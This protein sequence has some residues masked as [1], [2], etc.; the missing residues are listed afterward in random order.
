MMSMQL[1]RYI[2]KLTN[3][4]FKLDYLKAS[5]KYF[6]IFHNQQFYST[7][8]FFV[9]LKLQLSFYLIPIKFS[10]L[11]SL[12]VFLNNKIIFFITKENCIDYPL[13]TF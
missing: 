9:Y 5:W 11:Y 2:S 1:I 4:S 10:L 8:V 3:Y 7:K 12:Y 13:E 6:Y